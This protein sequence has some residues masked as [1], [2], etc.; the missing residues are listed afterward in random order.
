MSEGSHGGMEKLTRNGDNLDLEQ[1]LQ[2]TSLQVFSLDIVLRKV[3]AMFSPIDPSAV[4][5]RNKDRYVDDVASGGTEDGINT[6]AGVCVGGSN[7]FE[8]NQLL[9]KI[10]S[11]GSLKLKVIVTSGEQDKE[12]IARLGKFVLGIGWDP[13]CDLISIDI[14][15]SDMLKSFLNMDCV[16]NAVIPPRIPLGIVNRPHDVL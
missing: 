11:E 2:V 16:S 12:K 4:E 5:K 10:L 8:T 6:I 15:E 3:T 9:S 14:R 7:K 13:T 1:F